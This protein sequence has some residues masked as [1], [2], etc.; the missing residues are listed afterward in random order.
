MSHIV[1]PGDNRH[2]RNDHVV[3]ARGAVLLDNIYTCMIGLDGD[4]AHPG[5]ALDLAGRVNKSSARSS[6]LYLFDVEAAAKLAADLI[7]VCARAGLSA[8]V[9]AAFDE[10]LRGQM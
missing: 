4:T 2:G 8:E 3:D 10:H 7:G 6:V 1:G 9:M 5:V